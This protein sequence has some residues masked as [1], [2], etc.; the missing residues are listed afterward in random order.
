[1]KSVTT[2]CTYVLQ[3]YSAFRCISILGVRCPEP[4]LRYQ[5]RT[6]QLRGKNIKENVGAWPLNRL[7]T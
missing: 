6:I 1:M 5:R 7:R 3:K 2:V 4:E